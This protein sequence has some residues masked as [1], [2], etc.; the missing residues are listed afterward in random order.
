M[1]CLEFRQLKLSDPHAQDSDADEH[2]ETCKTCQQFLAEIV[3]LDQNVA[4]ALRVAV[5]E[6]F[7]AKIL[8]NQSLQNNPRWPTR[9]LWLTSMAAS[10]FALIL[11][12]S[13]YNTNN[14][15]TTK[16]AQL[17]QAI[18]EHMPHENELVVTLHERIDDAEIH[19]VLA[20]VN[21]FT[22][23]NLGN[24][25]YA[26]TC[27]LQGQL[28]AH[29]VVEQDSKQFTMIIA[30]FNELDTSTTFYSNEWR[31][32]VTPQQKGMLSVIAE[33]SVASPEQ[34]MRVTN[35]YRNSFQVV[36]A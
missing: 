35:L 13:V 34:V 14:V 25:V 3:Q 21:L 19:E 24:V 5:P 20:S 27:K 33:P 22:N 26:T 1:N 17:S 7:A 11:F 30:P 28:V 9:R 16:D 2:C 23:Q 8:L 12:A 10:F 18:I 6:G 29:L 15:Q 31:G 32:F 4:A 36:G